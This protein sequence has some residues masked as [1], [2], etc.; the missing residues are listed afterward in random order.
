LSQSYLPFNPSFLKWFVLHVR[1][2][3]EKRTAQRLANT[4]FEYF[5]PC[6]RSV[7]QWKDRRVTLEMPLFPGYVFVH[8]DLAD[9]MKVLTLPNVVGLIGSKNSPSIVLPEEIDR[10]KRGVEFGNAAPYSSF[11]V[12]QRVLIT[13]GA[14]R[15]MSGCLL[16]SGNNTRVAISI[17]SIARSFVVDVDISWLKP[18]A[19]ISRQERKA[20]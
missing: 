18:I 12:G 10:I 7:R 3:Q 17:D 1:V 6:Y 19:G 20:V 8:M 14:L 16:R 4:E 9:R 13:E 2:N 5:L 11:V 15:G